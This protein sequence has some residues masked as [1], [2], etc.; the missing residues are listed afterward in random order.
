MMGSHIAGRQA[1]MTML[2]GT[3]RRQLCKGGLLT[4]EQDIEDEEDGET[5]RVLG[6]IELEVLREAEQ[7]RVSDVGTVQEGEK[8]Q[9]RE[10]GTRRRSLSTRLVTR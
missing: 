10:P 2:E 9:K 8:V 3:D 7:V 5:D 4:F 1:F 6:V